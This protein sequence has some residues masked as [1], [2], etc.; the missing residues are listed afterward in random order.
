MACFVARLTRALHEPNRVELFWLASGVLRPW[1]ALAMLRPAA[2]R[3][4]VASF[5]AAARVLMRPPVALAVAAVRRM[6]RSRGLRGF[7]RA[8]VG[9]R[10]VDPDQPLDVAQ[11]A[12]LLVIA[13][14]DRDAVGAGARGAAD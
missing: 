6:M 10:N 11:E 14:R 5:V 8:A 2:L 13:E 9:R 1:S 3:T 4:L 7:C 12:A